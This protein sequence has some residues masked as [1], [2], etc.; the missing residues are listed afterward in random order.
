MNGAILVMGIVILIVGAIVIGIVLNKQCPVGQDCDSKAFLFLMLT[1]IF[2]KCETCTDLTDVDI[3][4]PS[5]KFCSCTAGQPLTED[6][7]KGKIEA[8][9]MSRLSDVS[10]ALLVIQV[11][12]V[13]ITWFTFQA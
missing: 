11:F 1:G 6:Q 4:M 3:V 7:C 8:I 5:R 12:F 9:T 13:A 2:C 10:V